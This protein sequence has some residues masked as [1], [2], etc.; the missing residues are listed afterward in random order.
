MT[1]VSLKDGSIEHAARADR[2]A[3]IKLR[4]GPR[5]VFTVDLE[6]YFHVS[7]FEGLAP[8]DG[9][10]SFSLRVEAST[11]RLLDLLDSHEA[12]A[13]FF[14]LGWLA[15]RRPKLLH[16]IAARGHEIAS[17]S[18]WHRRVTGMSRAE[19]TADALR[20]R[21]VLEQLVGVPI[22]GYRAPSF[23][24][25]ASN[26]WAFEA[27]V[28]CGY[29]Y[30][31]SVFPIRRRGYGFPGAPRDEY[32]IQTGAGVLLEFPLATCSFAGIPVPAAGGG[33]LRHFPYA[34]IDAS[35]RE[36]LRSDRVGVYYVHPWEIDVAQPRLATSRLTRLRHYGG[37]HRTEPRL[38]RLLAS[39]RFTSF[40]ML[41]A[42]RST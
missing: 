12:K 18:Y 16:Q 19:F 35:V 17:H 4:E 20:S 23:S 14:V 34:V 15:E 8:R 1:T 39:A 3:A 33:Y 42:E 10:D 7:A 29:E 32:Q 30:D 36:V 31:S 37:L 26:D 38:H 27:L 2:A 40:A 11:E 5:F 6:D 41:R 28:E 25:T 22:I 13:T 21:E 9:W 24:I